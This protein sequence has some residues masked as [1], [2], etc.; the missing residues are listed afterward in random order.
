MKTQRQILGS[1][2]EDAAAGYLVQRGY[3]VLDRNWRCPSG[4]LD[5]VVRSATGK[6]IG[7]EVKTR[8]SQRYGTGFEAVNPA[9]F[10]RLNRLLLL[11]AQQHG[12]FVPR[13]QIDVVEVYA[14]GTS[15]SIEHLQD[16]S[17]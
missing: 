1:R 12:V 14:L 16:V 8:S 4:E 5:L 6:I 13:L 10:R 11:W 17:S 15:W 2:G 7:V 9:K 3:K